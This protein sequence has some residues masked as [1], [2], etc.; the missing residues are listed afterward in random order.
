M[1]T[2]NSHVYEFENL[3][4]NKPLMSYDGKIQFA[5]WREKAKA[6]A[7]SF[8]SAPTCRLRTGGCS[9]MK[10]RKK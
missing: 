1:K 5:E 8:S 4:R 7:E 2:T 9:T 10:A 3:K 6:R